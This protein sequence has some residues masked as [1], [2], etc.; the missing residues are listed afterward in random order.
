[1]SAF[2]FEA[3]AQHVAILGK[4]GSGKTVVAK[5]LVEKL[6]A[7]GRLV[8]AVDPTGVWYGL[9]LK[10][11]GK[12]AAFPVVIFGGAHADIPIDP[13][14][15]AK[16]AEIVADGQFSCVIDTQLMKVDDRTKFFTDFA[17]A[18]L[19]FNKRALHLVIDEAHIFAPQQK[20]PSKASARLAHATN[21][22]VSG[23]RARGLRI[24]LISQRAAKL[25]KDSLT[26]VETLVA[27][28]LIAPQDVGAVKLWIK[29]WAD[30]KT[31][32]SVV[33]TLPSLR[34]GEGWVWAPEHGVL[35]RIKFPMTKT[36]DS[37]RAPADDES[38]SSVTLAEIDL[39]S[40]REA[41]TPKSVNIP[42]KGQERVIQKVIQTSKVDLAAAERRGYERGRVDEGRRLIRELRPLSTVAEIVA[43]I[44]S[45]AATMPSPAPAAQR[46]EQRPPKPSIVGLTPAGRTNG[47]AEH[48]LSGPQKQ[49]LASL[50]FWRDM[51]IEQP[52][53]AMV[54]GV[55]GW[56]VTSGHMNNVSG[57][58]RTLGLINYPS[59]GAVC[60]TTEGAAVAPSSDGLEVYPRLQ[61]FLDG[62]QM[63][64]VD[65]LLEK[66]TM[67]RGDL[68]ERAGWS[69]S[70]GH[71][72]NV[73]GSLR[74][75]GVIDYPK[76]GE[77]S[78]AEW[79]S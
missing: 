3:L 55:A 12:T 24:M 25:H 20:L 67:R 21:N 56:R 29:E 9:R 62:P 37:S 36:F 49:L 15:G 76:Q 44:L 50:M 46:I 30:E 69:E 43:R 40:I 48:G 8:C 18:L 38:L 14:S 34:V 35:E 70:S 75:L 60:L 79:I 59:G 28:K 68:A 13:W 57:T 66:R 45:A 4:T 58:L 73:L 71:V 78:L 63:R 51:G 74:S 19:R 33:A 42:A 7:E 17:E 10:A 41:L 53:R 23:G 32:A 61:R 64:V 6:L 47:Q 65:L 16:L 31:G 26:Q 77:V 52:T 22:L 54:A 27:M 2:P 39:V 5:G 72:N 1:M 11:D